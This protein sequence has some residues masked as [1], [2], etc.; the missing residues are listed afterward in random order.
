MNNDP[1]TAVRAALERLMQEFVSASSDAAPID[2]QR[3]SGLPTQVVTKRN[4][5]DFVLA[6]YLGLDHQ[7][8]DAW[9]EWVPHPCGSVCSRF[10][11]VGDKAALDRFRRLADTGMALLK[12]AAAA[13]GTIWHFDARLVRQIQLDRTKETYLYWM[14]A[15]H[16]TA[17]QCRTPFLDVTVGNWGHTLKPDEIAED[18]AAVMSKPTDFGLSALPIHPIMESLQD[19]F[20]SSAE[21]IKIWLDMDDVVHV[22]D[23]PD[24]PPI[25][26]PLP[27]GNSSKESDV[28]TPP[29]DSV[30]TKDQ[31]Q[32]PPIPDPNKLVMDRTTFTVS[33]RGHSSDWDNT[34]PFNV[35]E[36]LN[37]RPGFPVALSLLKRDVWGAVANIED[38]SVRKHISDVRMKLKEDGFKGITIV[39]KPKGSYTLILTEP[40]L[41]AEG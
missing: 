16:L 18:V 3:L 30:V 1:N 6:N 10:A 33:Y 19:V 22:G 20:R 5:D 15:L 23:W 14:E 26:L 37:R 35:L 32:V 13:A 8:K 27:N 36:R 40:P 21:A 12:S 29:P 4:W 25:Y 28:V 11:G 34:K 24:R 31:D 41:L 2:H 38:A 9:R 39:D 17:K 7:K